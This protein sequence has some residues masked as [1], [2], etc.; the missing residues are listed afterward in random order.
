MLGPTPASLD[1]AR[2]LAAA[3]ARARDALG[4][5]PLLTVLRPGVREEQSAVSLAQWAAKGAH[6]LS[7][8]L[9]LEPGDRLHL[10]AGL[11][12]PAVAVLYA[13]WWSGVVVELPDQQ[14][15]SPSDPSDPSN[16]SDPSDPATVAVLQEGRPASAGVEEVLWLGDAIDGGPSAAVGGEAWTRAC[17][18]FPDHPPPPQA[19]PDTLALVVG[20]L[21]W[22]HAQLLERARSLGLDGPFG[23][24]VATDGR[25]AA[26]PAAAGEAADQAAGEPRTLAVIA[27]SAVRPL[28][29]GRPTAVLRGVDRAAASG[30]R[31]R[32][33]LLTG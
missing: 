17:Q 24:E 3:L 1:G 9:L 11:G 20:G 10:D 27:A 8:D 2:D 6:L 12:W 13:A 15:P 26:G 30:E 21:E 7:A 19:G 23:V 29:A 16:P 22:T 18:A 5:R 28:L 33:W 14:P 25:W 31:I 4:H 32:G